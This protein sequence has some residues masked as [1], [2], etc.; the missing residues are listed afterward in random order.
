MKRAEEK[1]MIVLLVPIAGIRTR[2]GKNVPRTLPMVEMPKMRPTEPPTWSVRATIRMR[3]GLVMP[4]TTIGG[5]NKS[6]MAT[7]DPK[8]MNE[9]AE[10]KLL[11]KYERNWT[12][13]IAT[14]GSRMR[15]A[16]AARSSFSRISSLGFRSAS[17]PP[18]T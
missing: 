2:T 11:I 4:R 10:L 17:F 15:N 16:Q 18:I 13:G 6:V 8:N 9:K 12:T 3:K 7:S 5:E 14:K 1:I